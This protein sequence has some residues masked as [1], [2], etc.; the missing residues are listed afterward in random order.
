MFSTPIYDVTSRPLPP[1]LWYTLFLFRALCALLMIFDLKNLRHGV[2]GPMFWLGIRMSLQCSSVA[3]YPRRR[4]TS[5]CPL[6]TH[7]SGYRL[8]RMAERLLN[9]NLYLE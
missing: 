6:Q 7:T 9:T 4:S 1:P 2:Q 3:W 8:D 5:G